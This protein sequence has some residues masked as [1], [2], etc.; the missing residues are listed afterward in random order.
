MGFRTGSFAKIWDIEDKGRSTRVRMSVSRKNRET[1]EYEQ[2]F[3]GYCSLI[4]TAHAKA[5]R[6][7]KGDRIRLG[8]VDVS[9]N[10][11]KEQNRE[12]VNYKCFS[13][14]FA[15]EVD[16]QSG[17]AQQRRNAPADSN[18]TESNPVD[19]VPEDLPF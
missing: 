7:K 11:N 2:D 18:P 4:G 8:E 13:F 1:G 14:D 9:T 5:S 10:F 6:L 15:D 3:S 19:D 12:Y 16:S 17:G